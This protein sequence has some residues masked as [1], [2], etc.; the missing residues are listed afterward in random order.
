MYMYLGSDFT[1]EAP[2]PFPLSYYAAVSGTEL[3][4]LIELPLFET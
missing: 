2:V 3:A 4:F 1:L